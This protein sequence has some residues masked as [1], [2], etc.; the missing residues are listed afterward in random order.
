[1]GSSTLGTKLATKPPQLSIRRPSG[2]T[3]VVTL[4]RDLY[5][6]GRADTNALCFNDVLGLSRKHLVFERAGS[7]WVVR[8]LGSTNGTYVNGTRLEAPHALRPKDRITA[9]DLNMVFAEAGAPAAQTVIFVEKPGAA[10]ETTST[11]QETT[12]TA[13]L[14]GLLAEEGPGK[15]SGHIQALIRAGRELAGHMPLDKLFDLILN[16]SIDAVGASRG[17]LMTLEQGQ[18]QVRASKGEGIRISSHVRDLVIGGK[19]SLLVHDALMDQALAGRMSIVQDQIRS[20]LAVP[21]QTEDRVIGLIY[22][23]SPF[24]VREFTKEDL[25]L[26][27]VMSNIAAI[28]IEHARLVE[29]EQVE[30]L[31]A[32]EME[33]AAMIQRSILPS[34]FPPFPDRKEFQL[35]AAM[36]P[37][38]GVGGD[39]FDFFLLDDEHLAL[40]VGDVS[41]KGVPAALFMAI[42][43]TLLRATAKHLASPADCLAYL[44][45]ALKEQNV[46]GMFVTFFY[47]VLNTRTGEIRFSNAGHNSPYI[48][49]KDG[50][51]RNLAEEGGPMLGLFEGLGFSMATTQLAPGEGI[52]VFTD[53]VTEAQDKDEEFFGDD[54]LEAYLR[55]HCLEPAEELVSGLQRDVQEFAAGAPQSDDITALALRYLG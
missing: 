37:A 9:G 14:D 1:M 45:S 29:M 4:E 6:L 41:G 44:N 2:E 10:Q 46:S 7:E 50:T 16:L 28:R 34:N 23:D 54:R 52:L 22:L 49:S 15:G 35:H 31:R 11:T 12:M 3:Q 38:R 24:L 39:P 30:K 26:L 33:H 8:D 42:T 55:A 32:Q 17:A 48:F 18:L 21:L 5:E 27:T 53:G 51:L 36:T 43:R 25:S 19:R 20:M 40:A 13:S 47:C